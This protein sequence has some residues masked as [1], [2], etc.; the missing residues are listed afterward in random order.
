[1]SE[2]IRAIDAEIAVMETDHWRNLMNRSKTILGHQRVVE[3][4][5]SVPFKECWTVIIYEAMRKA[6]NVEQ[7][8]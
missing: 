4:V 8:S 6:C 2:A 7:Q 1:M 5:T 3:V